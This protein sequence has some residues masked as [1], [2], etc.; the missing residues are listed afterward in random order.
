MK[1]EEKRAQ[2]QDRLR[3]RGRLVV[4]YSGGIDSTYLLK[5]ATETLGAENVLGVTAESPSLPMS[6]LEDARRLAKEHGFNHLVI[7]THEHENPEYAANPPNRCH[8]CK[9]ELYTQVVPIAKERGHT[10]IASGANADDTGDWRPGLKAAEEHGVIHPL[11]EVAL[12]KSEIRALARETG[13]D[14]W[15]KPAAACLASRFPYGTEITTERLK[16]VERAEEFLRNEV[17]LRQLRVRWEEGAARIECDPEAIPVAAAAH[18]RI[19]EQFTALGF[20]NVSLDLRGY[21]QGSLNEG[22]VQLRTSTGT[23]TD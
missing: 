14:T 2:L 21:R 10:W 9:S 17:G 16:M 1:L 12:T 15:D 8:F 7:Q 20:K 11:L 23:T 18:G 13:L 19:T 6:E 22:L 4:A 3:E 5:I